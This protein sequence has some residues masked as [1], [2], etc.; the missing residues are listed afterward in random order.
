MLKK[1]Y[2]ETVFLQDSEESVT[3][4]EQT[5]HQIQ[6]NIQS[7]KAQSGCKLSQNERF[8][9]IISIS[10]DSEKETKSEPKESDKELWKFII[11]HPK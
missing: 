4:K 1:I 7:Y 3:D 6:P 9:E 10:S 8:Q 2:E 5:T 11:R